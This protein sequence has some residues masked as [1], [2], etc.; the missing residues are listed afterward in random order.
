MNRQAHYRCDICGEMIA[1]N[2]APAASRSFY[3]TKHREIATTEY[4]REFWNRHADKYNA[5]RRKRDDRLSSD[6]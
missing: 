1:V 2:R 3:C 6:A 5:A 4:K